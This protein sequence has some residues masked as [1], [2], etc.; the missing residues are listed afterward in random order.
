M[1]RYSENISS[2]P[3]L[4]IIPR[5]F[6][7][8]SCF[9]IFSNGAAVHAAN[10]ERTN[11]EILSIPDFMFSMYIKITNSLQEVLFVLYYLYFIHR[12]HCLSLKSKIITFFY[13]IFLYSSIAIFVSKIEDYFLCGRQRVDNLQKR[14]DIL[15]MCIRGNEM[16]QIISDLV[17]A[18]YKSGTDLSVIF[19]IEFLSN[20]EEKAK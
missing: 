16:L 8:D 7:F 15:A 6:L 10:C 13:N 18:E 4:K 2:Y 19:L 11:A 14:Q 17:G 9:L 3:S 5:I 12:L 1:L 20:Q